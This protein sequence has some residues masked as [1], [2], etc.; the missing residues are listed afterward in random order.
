ME[1]ALIGGGGG[2][3]LILR[4]KHT[5][6]FVE[7]EVHEFMYILRGI[8][9]QKLPL[10]VFLAEKGDEGKMHINIYF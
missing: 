5:L 4:A 1:S 8:G 2:V 10:M 6:E 9:G 7:V 3:E